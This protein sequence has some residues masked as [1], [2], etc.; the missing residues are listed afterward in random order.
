M[1]FKF[2]NGLTHHLHPYD[3]PILGTR[4]APREIVLDNSV[5]QPQE[6]NPVR[7][8]TPPRAIKLSEHHFPSATEDQ[9]TPDDEHVNAPE[10]DQSSIGSIDDRR[11][12]VSKPKRL[13][14]NDLFNT[15]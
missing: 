4:T 1:H 15:R 5:L 9:Y 13:F 12:A 2:N 11:L 6:P 10:Y 8:S 14:N 7:V 3:N